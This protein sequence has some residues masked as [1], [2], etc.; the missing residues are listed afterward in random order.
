MR[1]GARRLAAVVPA[2]ALLL[3]ACGGSSSPSAP[4][5]GVIFTPQG[6]PGANSIF[7][8]QNPASNEDRLFLDVRANEVT[9]LFGINLEIAYPRAVLQYAAASEGDFLAGPN[10]V[11]TSF[12]V[13]EPAQG[14]LVIG[15]TRLR[16]VQGRSGSGVLCTLEFA[17]PASGTGSFTFLDTEAFR[18]G[19]TLDPGVTWLAGSVQ[20]TR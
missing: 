6:T 2:L 8:S 19:P 5:R 3:A 15:L 18:P 10:N 1:R 9:N 11:G 12:V 7:L 13:A 4:R 20:V 17:L 16:D 14:E